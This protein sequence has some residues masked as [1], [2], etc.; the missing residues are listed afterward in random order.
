MAMVIFNFFND[1]R[2]IFLK[3]EP[4]S[5]VDYITGVNTG[6]TAFFLVKRALLQIISCKRSAVGYQ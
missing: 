4:T 3:F 1:P 5:H 2:W 6:K